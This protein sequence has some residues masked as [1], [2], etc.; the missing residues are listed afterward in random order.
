MGNIKAYCFTKLII[1][2]KSFKFQISCEKLLQFHFKNGFCYFI[3]N[4]G[5]NLF[6]IAPETFENKNCSKVASTS[7]K[8]IFYSKI[9]LKY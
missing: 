5:G 1:H 3:V 7:L 2:K 4:F 6:K 9:T 8:N